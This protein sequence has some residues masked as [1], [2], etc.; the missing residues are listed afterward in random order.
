MSVTKNVTK[1]KKVVK[2]RILAIA[3][4]QFTFKGVLY[5]IGDYFEGKQNEEN[6]LINKNLIKWQ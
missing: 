1:K 2:K 5:K 4:V 6:L 3:I